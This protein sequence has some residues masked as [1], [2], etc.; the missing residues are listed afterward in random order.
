MKQKVDLRL[1]K[2][3]VQK[4]LSISIQSPHYLYI[5]T[6]L[7]ECLV[8]KIKLASSNIPT[9]L[10]V[11]FDGFYIWT[12]FCSPFIYLFCFYRSHLGLAIHMTFF[13]GTSRKFYC[14][15][16]NTHI[17][18]ILFNFL[19]RERVF[20]THWTKKFQR[21]INET[22]IRVYINTCF[23]QFEVDT[24]HAN[25]GPVAFYCLTNIL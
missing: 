17:E 13:F 10:S 20:F 16:R 25:K 24:V 4:L 6:Y 8:D 15:H 7:S 1:L 14:T 21:Q 5:Y 23:R 19:S 18:F 2:V 12:A 3:E 11:S 22:R 9:A